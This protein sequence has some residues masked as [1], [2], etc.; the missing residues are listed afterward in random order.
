MRM[1]GQEIVEPRWW[2]LGRWLVWWRATGRLV[3]LVEEHGGRLRMVKKRAVDVKPPPPLPIRLAG[4]KTILPA[5]S[6]EAL[7]QARKLEEDPR[8][9]QVADEVLERTGATY[10]ERE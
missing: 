1:G 4:G 3:F 7:K 10:R 6:E 2:Q 9:R 8:L 5:S